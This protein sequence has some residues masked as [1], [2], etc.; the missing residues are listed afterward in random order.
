MSRTAASLASEAAAEAG[1]DSPAWE[2]SVGRPLEAAR[3]LNWRSRSVVMAALLGCLALF[4]LVRALA[5]TPTLDASW[6]ADASGRLIVT[7]VHGRLGMPAEPATL[8]GLLDAHG[9]PLPV[10]ATLLQRAPRWIVD[11]EERH[12]HATMH[13]RLNAAMAIGPVTL[14]LAEAPPVGLRSH[15]RGITGLGAGFWLMATL[16]L[17]LYLTAA[18]VLAARPSERNAMYAV[19]AFC[20]A[21]NLVF[22]AA[23]SMP[24]LLL[25]PWLLAL[26]FPVRTCLDLVTAAALVHATGLHPV[27]VRARWASAT[28]AWCLAGLLTVLILAGQLP[29]AWWWVQGAAL[30]LGALTVLQLS[31]QRQGPPHPAALLLRRLSTVAMCTLLLLSLAMAAASRRADI[32]HFANAI[33]STVWVVFLSSLL[34]LLPFLSRSQQVLREFS[35]LAGVSTVATSL[36]L[37]FVAAFSLSQFASVTLALFISLGLYAGV[38]QWLLNRVLGNTVLTTERAFEQLYRLARELE[39]RPDQVGTRLSQLLRELFEPLEAM[40]VHRHAP[41]ARVTGDGSTLIVPVP[42]MPGG[43]AL[44]PETSILLRYA[45]KGTR[46]FCDEDARLATRICEQ[47]RRAVAFDQA[48]E[49]GRSEERARLAQDLHDDIGA[50][51]LT[52]MYK[53]PDPETEEYV[54]HTLKDLKTLTRGLAASNHR[55]SHAAAEWKADISQR[56]G[57]VHCDLGW[58]FSV[59]ED[60]ALNVVQW[61]ALTRALRE[62]I[63]NVISH[64]AATRVEVDGVYD[65]GQ[66]TITVSDNGQGADPESWMHG[67]GLNGVRK[68]VRQLSGHVEWRTR[69]PQGIQCRIWIPSLAASARHE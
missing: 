59:D 6:N 5:T 37:L 62:L 40:L 48:V 38:R 25:P 7:A 36:D 65:K 12:R 33:G 17:A 46:I 23:E 16:A 43:D 27:P 10:S 21:A 49:Q 54:R 56:L 24:G 68:R 13:E 3:A 66:L 47:L 50:R 9:R 19:M 2:R 35:M 30:T 57:A 52:L 14:V 67:L 60:V 18:V 22:I 45:R 31:S 39:G 55:L 63:N 26:D 58:S 8:L 15:P 42:A 32:A 34:G 61:S 11:D 4:L 69:I 28:L 53:A 20:Q 51:L 41:A 44:A 64:A 1:L 29:A